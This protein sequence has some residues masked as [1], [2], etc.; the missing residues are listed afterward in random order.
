[1]NEQ[2][3]YCCDILVQLAAVRSAL[4]QVGAEMATA[5]VQSCIMGKGTGS[6]HEKSQA[7]SPEELVD[8][9]RTTLT[10]LMR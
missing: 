2:G 4:D 1:M 8:E 6:E 9:L 5:H 7:M 10:R 3:E